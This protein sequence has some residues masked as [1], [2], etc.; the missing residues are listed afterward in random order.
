MSLK[1]S[2]LE[3]G[4]NGGGTADNSKSPFI[5][6]NNYNQDDRLD[7]EEIFTQHMQSLSQ[8]IGDDYDEE[9]Y[10]DEELEDSK[11]VAVKELFKNKNNDDVSTTKPPC[12]YDVGISSKR[13]STDYTTTND[14]EFADNFDDDVLAKMAIP[15][16]SNNR[17]STEAEFEDDDLDNQ[18]SNLN[19]AAILSNS[20][21]S[22]NNNSN[23]SGGKVK[24]E[25]EKSMLQSSSSDKQSPTKMKQ[26]TLLETVTALNKKTAQNKKRRISSIGTASSSSAKGNV[27]FTTTTAKKDKKTNSKSRKSSGSTASIQT[28]TLTQMFSG[29]PDTPQSTSPN[30]TPKAI[31]ENELHEVRIGTEI[32]TVKRGD[33]WLPRDKALR[34]EGFAFSIGDISMENIPKLIG[35]HKV[36]QITT[37]WKRVTMAFIGAEEATAVKAFTGSDWVR[38]MKHELLPENGKIQLKKLLG[39]RIMESMPK[40]DTVLCYETRGRVDH[41]FYYQTGKPLPNFHHAE[42]PMAM[43]LFAG[44]G[45]ASA[46]LDK[47]GFNVKYK[48]EMNKSA[49]DTLRMNFPD[50]Y[51]FDEP[52]ATFIQNCKDQRVHIYPR[53]DKTVSY[54]HASP[55]CQGMSAVN[56]S[57]GANDLQN[58]EC[59]IT[60]L[61]AVRLFQADFVTMENVPGLTQQKNIKYLLRIVGGLLSMGYQVNVSMPSAKDFGDPQ[62][63]VRVILLASKKGY[64]LPV[65]EPT[66]GQGRLD[67]V[68]AGSALRDLEDVNPAPGGLVGLSGGRHVFDHYKEGTELSEKADNHYT[69]NRDHPA[70]TV[71][72]ANQIRHYRHSDRY[73]TVRER[74]RIQSFPD[75]HRFAGKRTDMYNQIGNAIPVNLAAA[76]GRAIMKSYRAGPHEMPRDTC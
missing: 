60:F 62:D 52:I 64:K 56:T 25:Q 68:T 46:G 24:T 28:N 45:G 63:R 65:L 39:K 73:I 18:M 36:A 19:E 57:G 7:I 16:P 43:D 21:S 71:R 6:Y 31:N 20:N 51:V 10:S 33:V 70:N 40:K 55:P 1:Q 59:T 22:F 69:L 17:M 12:A 58:N 13:V 75:T 8:D 76:I 14:N 2:G 30:N 32:R 49:A 47:A 74:A 44:G 35:K 42:H 15:P 34:D 5:E 27:S 37:A 38:V 41:S 67:I 48:V 3:G 26:P 72:K 23:S 54:M 29:A 9:E 53:G 66:H 11:P 50:S 4:D 61:E